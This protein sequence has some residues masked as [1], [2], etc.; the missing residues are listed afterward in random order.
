MLVIANDMDDQSDDLLASYIE[1]K[2]ATSNPSDIVEIKDLKNRASGLGIVGGMF[3]TILKMKTK[4][5][6]ELLITR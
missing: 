2:S 5:F 6:P 1:L 4:I 3:R